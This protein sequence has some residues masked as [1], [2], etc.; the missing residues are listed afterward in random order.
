M[1]LAYQRI[2]ANQYF[3]RTHAGQKIDYIEERNGKMNWKM[4]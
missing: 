4:I 2:N 1:Q 3:W